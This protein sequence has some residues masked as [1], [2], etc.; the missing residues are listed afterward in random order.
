MLPLIPK[1][2]K[3]TFESPGIEL[4]IEPEPEPIDV[5][6]IGLEDGNILGYGA[7]IGLGLEV[8]LDYINRHFLN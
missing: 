3:L 2:N 1:R 6:Y 8:S 7:T 4:V 5:T